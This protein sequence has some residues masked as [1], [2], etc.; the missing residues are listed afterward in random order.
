MAGPSF[1]E[2]FVLETLRTNQS[3]LL[4]RRAQRDFVFDGFLI[5]KHATVRVCLWESH[6][7]PDAFASPLE[8]Q[9]DRFLSAPP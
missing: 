1:T 3:E 4:M 9:P 5:P 8:F 6:K 7:S 2:A